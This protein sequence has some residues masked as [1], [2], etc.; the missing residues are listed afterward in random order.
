MPD[1]VSL[2]VGSEPVKRIAVV[3]K[4]RLPSVAV[5]YSTRDGD[6]EVLDGGKPMR[7]SDSMF[8][9][10]RMRYEVDISDHHL[11]MRFDEQPLPTQ[12]DI[13]HFH[14]EVSVSFRVTNPAEVIRRN[15]TDAVP[16]VRGHLLGACRPI[17]RM[18]SIE[19]AEEAEAAL[20]ARFRRD[21]MIY[22]GITIYAVSAR[23]SLD[24]AGRAWL[25]EIQ[26]AQRDEQVKTARHQ[27][28]VCD[29]NRQ[30]EINLL[31]QGGVHTIQ[32]RERIRLN[33]RPLDTATL[34]AIHLERNPG[35]TLGAAKM[36]A[37]LEEAHR[38]EQVRQ[39][40]QAQAVLMSLAEN[41]HVQQSDVQ[42]LLDA[43]VDRL[44]GPA[45]VIRTTASV[46]S[47][48]PA[49]PQRPSAIGWDAPLSGAIATPEGDHGP[50]PPANVLPVYLL[51]DESPAAARWTDELSDAVQ[52]LYAA[53]ADRPLITP[54][55]RLSILGFAEKVAER[56]PL[57]QV[58]AG[59]KPPPFLS[60]GPAD[61]A[62]LFRRLADHIPG[63]MNDLRAEH[64]SVR[65]PLLI[66][67]TASP[68]PDDDWVVPRRHLASRLRRADVIAVGVGDATAESVAGFA[69][70]PDLAFVAEDGSAAA[71]TQFSDFLRHY[72]ISCAE[73]ALAGTESPQLT[74][75]A[76]YRTADTPG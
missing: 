21:T 40:D 3:S 37:E 29:V 43:S 4:G 5:V 45:K 23:L 34:I 35:D 63:E 51:V 7:W 18:Y 13:Y 6:L 61:H 27:T 33:G 49:A 50:K 19:D 57:E 65:G 15:V 2:I 28:D 54:A 9:K 26:Q 25:Q 75:P 38:N 59:R 16:L 67:L 73:A 24:E 22:G 64:P 10:Y 41:G 68:A 56:L 62:E 39:D 44:A 32:D 17:T 14:A 58:E 72:I 48:Q 66:L 76:G 8:T 42:A 20:H 30:N 1:S 71:I 70:F 60:R 31:K 52:D 74:A 46:Q 36:A 47:P 53:I 69:S 12:D 11:S 55:I